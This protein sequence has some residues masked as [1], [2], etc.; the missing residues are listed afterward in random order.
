MPI[1]PVPGINLQKQN[2]HGNSALQHQHRPLDEILI[3]Q[4]CRRNR[5]LNR[6]RKSEL[7]SVQGCPDGTRMQP[8][9][10]GE[11]SR[12]RSWSRRAWEGA[13]RIHSL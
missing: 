5:R 13:H 3:W 11:S 4:R 10:A 7:E 9:R 8:G 2:L 6:T 1:R 12:R